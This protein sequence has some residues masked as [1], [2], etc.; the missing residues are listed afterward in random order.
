MK[1]NE[2]Q[3]LRS[4]VDAVAGMIGLPIPE[5]SRPVVV[6]NLEVACRMAKMLEEIKIDER[7]DPAPVFRP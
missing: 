2:N 5:A 7:E 1:D 6:A 4:Y 3:D